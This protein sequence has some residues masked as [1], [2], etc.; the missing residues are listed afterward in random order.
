MYDDAS[1]TPHKI[2]SST[3]MPL[4]PSGRC[5]NQDRSEFSRWIRVR[6]KERYLFINLTPGLQKG[7][8]KK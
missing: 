5:K 7:A 3:K 2:N 1:L 6:G 8:E 4:K